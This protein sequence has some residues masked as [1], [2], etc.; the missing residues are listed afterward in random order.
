[1]QNTFMQEHRTANNLPSMH[2]TIPQTECL[3]K[4]YYH[5]AETPLQNLAVELHIIFA[6]YQKPMHLCTGQ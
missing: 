4:Y 5:M 6:V 2:C 3:F 1:M